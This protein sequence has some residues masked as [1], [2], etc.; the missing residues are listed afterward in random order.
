MKVIHPENYWCIPT[1]E[2]DFRPGISWQE[3]PYSVL[4]KDLSGRLVMTG[5]SADEQMDIRSLPA[6]I[7]M[8]TT[9]NA[10][11]IYIKQ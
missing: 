8:L 5:N 10:G 1:G 11:T 9:G 2:T 6:G 7:Y 3:Q 4:V